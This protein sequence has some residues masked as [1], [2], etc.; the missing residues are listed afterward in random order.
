MSSAL[1]L[2]RLEKQYQPFARF[3]VYPD[4]KRR[5]FYYIAYVFTTRTQMQAFRKQLPAH[6]SVGKDYQALTMPFHHV[7]SG[8]ENPYK[9]FG[10]NIGLILFHRRRTG[11]GVVSH[12]M[13]HA[14]CHYLHTL[15]I[16]SVSTSDQPEREELLALSVGNLTRQFINRY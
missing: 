13:T 10:R 7:I 6:D 4:P 1:N 11:T 16:N 2:R 8:A 15:G 14:A 9:R 5:Y 12:E 3:R